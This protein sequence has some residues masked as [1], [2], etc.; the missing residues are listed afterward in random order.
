MDVIYDIY[1]TKIVDFYISFGAWS[2]LFFFLFL[3]TMFVLLY[4][5]TENTISMAF[6]IKIKEVIKKIETGHLIEAIRELR[7]LVPQLSRLEYYRDNLDN[8]EL[9]YRYMLKYATEGVDDPQRGDIYKKICTELKQ[10]AE[11]MAEEK[12][13]LSGDDF[14]YAT[15]GQMRDVSVTTAVERYRN[16][17]EQATLADDG[18]VV[19]AA[20]N[21]EKAE[22]DVFKVVW[23]KRAFNDAERSLLLDQIADIAASRGV[24]E[25]I[26]S[27]LTLRLLRRFCESDLTMLLDVYSTSTDDELQVR[28]IV[29]V[30]FALMGGASATMSRELRLRLETMADNDTYR[31]DL[32][33]V[34]LQMARSKGT[35]RLRKKVVNEIVSKLSNMASKIDRKGMQLQVFDD[36]EMLKNPEWMRALEES[37]VTDKMME[38]SRLHE[39][40]NDVF[41]ESFARLKN[42]SF[43]SEMSNWFLSFDMHRSE[44]S[45]VASDNLSSM[46]DVITVSGA[47][48]DS[49][50]YSFMLSIATLPDD[51][52]SLMMQSMSAQAQ[53]FGESVDGALASRKRDRRMMIR[54]LLQNYY[55]FFDIYVR[56]THLTMVNPFDFDTRWS[57]LCV[58]CNNI[59]DAETLRLVGEI[60]FEIEEYGKALEVFE[61]L[62][63]NEQTAATL[64][65]KEGYCLERLGSYEQAIKSYDKAE[66][67]NSDNVWTL[68][69]LAFCYRLLGNHA[70]ALTVYRKVDRLQPDNASTINMIGNCL[71]ETG[72]FNEALKC[73]FKVNYLSPKG[74][75]SLRPIAWCSLRAANY[76]QSIDYYNK[77]IA[78]AEPGENVSIDYVNRGHARLLSGDVK[79]ATDDYITAARKSNTA[80]LQKTM[81]LDR[82]MLVAAGADA[83]LLTFI[84]ERSRFNDNDFENM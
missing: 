49:D 35:N 30:Y 69:H 6:Y 66:L 50:I 46:M 51:K 76:E 64:Y 2:F 33:T 27:A 1:L 18:S 78:S 47:F 11:E 21:L 25:L 45:A 22:A 24:K 84:V 39:Q 19:T 70:A 23:T 40:G 16:A 55:R 10:I 61:S 62:D 36:T 71:M 4:L 43:F 20:R 42:Y 74:A 7:L 81:T 3:G 68:R 29:G 14:Y 63:H 52:R 59:A 58:L 48:C 26:L 72:D 80:F 13:E 56:R 28:A 37:G 83:D 57:D 17:L 41:L 60:Y 32:S 31:S 65:Q 54:L 53:Q 44:L 79:A 34:F 67:V 82:D 75:K 15:R 38:L 77:V 8:L 5:Y 9:S 12:H 73:Y